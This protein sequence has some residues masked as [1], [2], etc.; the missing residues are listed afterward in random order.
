MVE[1]LRRAQS[2]WAARDVA[3][4]ARAAARI[5]ERVLA[6]K[7]AAVRVLASEL[8]AR[9]V[10]LLVGEV[11][12]GAE[13]ANYWALIAEESLAP[14]SRNGPEGATVLHRAPRGVLSIEVPARSPVAGTLRAAVPALVAGNAVLLTGASDAARELLAGFFDDVINEKILAFGEVGADL[15]RLEAPRPGE[16]AAFVLEDAAVERA[17]E[18]LTDAAL[19]RAGMWGGPL[20]VVFV[21]AAVFDRFAARFAALT[22]ARGVDEERVELVRV[23]SFDDAAARAAARGRLSLASVWSKRIAGELTRPI[24]A[25]VVVVGDVTISER[26]AARAFAPTLLER[27]TRPVV[28]AGPRASVERV[29]LRHPASPLAERG[30]RA[31]AESRGIGAVRRARALLTLYGVVSRRWSERER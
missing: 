25:S 16:S 6:A 18:A 24:D 19:A 9:E 5:A 15:E 23:E 10:E 14:I 22:K 17:A 2:T 29:L 3:F 30:A 1:E 21:H 20:R 4:R 7:D 27:V 26:A 11:I 31:L 13:L 12:A 8:G 28:V